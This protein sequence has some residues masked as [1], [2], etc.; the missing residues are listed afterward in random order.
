MKADRNRYIIINMKSYSESF[1]R[2]STEIASYLSEAQEEYGVRCGVCP[3]IP[4]LRETVGSG[5]DVY[6]QHCDPNE[7][8]A[9]TGF[10]SPEMIADAGAS[11]VLLNHSEHR[12]KLYEIENVIDRSR[13]AHLRTVVCADTPR[14][15]AAVC[16]LNPDVV[17]IEPPELIGSGIS[18]SMARPEVIV[19][20]IAAAMK[21]GS[22]TTVIAGAGISGPADVKR[23]YELGAAGV[24]V[25]SA[26][27]KSRERRKLI[28]E[29]ASEL[30]SAEK[31]NH[32][33]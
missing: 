24:L 18:V 26:V 20:S 7:P 22:G 1:G 8:G 2:S 32:I 6:A 5:V 33:S 17:A 19:E 12:M 28:L 25:A 10:T 14:A 4:W 21:S 16:A 3:P 29:M 27:V 11:G 31:K 13:A 30:A 23:A 9:A 15:V